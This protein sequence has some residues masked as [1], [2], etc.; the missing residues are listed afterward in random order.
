MRLAD[1]QGIAA[2]ADRVR[3]RIAAAG[4]DPASVLL[5]AVTKGFPPDVALAAATCGL[6]DL[7]ENYAQEM[8]PKVVAANAAG[9]APRWHF[10]GR[11]QRNK[12]KLLAPHVTLWQSVDR[13][14]LGA[15]IA[16]RAPGAEVLVQVNLS[17]QGQKGGCERSETGALVEA[18]ADLGLVV[19]GLMG[20]APAGAPEGARECFRWLRAE[21][22]HLGL[23]DCS[24]GMSADLEVAVQEG[25]TMVRVGTDL[26]GRRP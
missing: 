14:A 16:R 3:G 25:A 7:G 8:V 1:P 20:V 6:D 17:G 15:E 11:L 19:R 5:V 24:M 21:A 10:L 18:L 23:R 13:L 9:L 26:F 4:G 22:D 2:G 12:V